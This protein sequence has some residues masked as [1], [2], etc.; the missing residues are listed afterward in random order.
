MHG[1]IV[2]PL[3]IAEIGNN[4]EGDLVLAEKMIE[5]AHEAGAHAVKFQTFRTEEYISNANPERFE[6]M[7]SLYQKLKDEHVRKVAIYDRWA[8]GF[9]SNYVISCL[10]GFRF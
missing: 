5:A 10:R 6:R 8:Y 4:H 7:K 9:T 3:V 1:E 2:N